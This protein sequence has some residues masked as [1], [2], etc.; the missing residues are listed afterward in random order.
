[1]AR[2][3]REYHTLIK[4]RKKLIEVVDIKEVKQKTDIDFIDTILKDYN[5]YTQDM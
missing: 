2:A 3:S 1:M 4:L 5:Y